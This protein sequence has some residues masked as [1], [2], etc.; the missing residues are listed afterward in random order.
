MYKENRDYKYAEQR[1]DGVC[2]ENFRHGEG[3]VWSS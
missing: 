2:G 3:G 1:R